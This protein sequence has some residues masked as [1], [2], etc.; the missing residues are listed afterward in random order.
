MFVPRLRR[1]LSIFV[2]V[3]AVGPAELLLRGR[4]KACQRA[5]RDVLLFRG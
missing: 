5:G 4:A 3:A 2:V 1:S